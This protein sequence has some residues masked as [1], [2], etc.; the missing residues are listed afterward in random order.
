MIYSEFDNT[1]GVGGHYLYIDPADTTIGLDCD[2]DCQARIQTSAS[3]KK[4]QAKQLFDAQHVESI[5]NNNTG[6]IK[7]TESIAN[8]N[9]GSIQQNRKYCK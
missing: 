9:T 2:D 3:Y 8:N 4:P 6:S 5:A 7:Q 1:L